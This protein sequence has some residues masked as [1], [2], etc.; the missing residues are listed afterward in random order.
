MKRR[1][2]RT[3]LAVGCAVSWLAGCETLQRFGRRPASDEP[4]AKVAKSAEPVEDG[5]AESKAP[6]G[7]KGFFKSTRLPGGLSSEANDIERSLG[8]Q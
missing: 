7:P 3:G 2:L 4:V 1:I 5:E 6:A 8:V